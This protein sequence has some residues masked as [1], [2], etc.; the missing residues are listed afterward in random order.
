[1]R[2]YN[3]ETFAELYRI[4]HGPKPTKKSHKVF[5]GMSHDRARQVFSKSLEKIK[6]LRV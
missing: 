1:M 6:N 5:G 2:M 3:K 4:A